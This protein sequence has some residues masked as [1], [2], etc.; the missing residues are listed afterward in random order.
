VFR[1]VDEIKPKG[2]AETVA[3]YELAGERDPGAWSRM[4]PQ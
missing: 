3:I 4:V 2:S 1:R